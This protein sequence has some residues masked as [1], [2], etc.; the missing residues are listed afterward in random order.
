MLRM[1]DSRVTFTRKN[2]SM[3]YA[4]RAMV[5]KCNDHVQIAPGDLVV[6]QGFLFHMRNYTDL[7]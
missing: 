2:G 3:P 4:L 5:V 7:T 6:E 1:L